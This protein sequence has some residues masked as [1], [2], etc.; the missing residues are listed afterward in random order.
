MEDMVNEP[1]RSKGSVMRSEQTRGMG[2]LLGGDGGGPG[3]HEG[4]DQLRRA[5]LPCGRG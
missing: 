5:V 2:P 3:V 4:H 1:L